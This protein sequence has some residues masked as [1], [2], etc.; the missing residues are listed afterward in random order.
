MGFLDRL[1]RKRIYVLPSIH[2]SM[3]SRY[4]DGFSAGRAQGYAAGVQAAREAVA[5]LPYPRTFGDYK[6]DALAAI[7]ALREEHK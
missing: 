3:A 1:H 7:D 2:A 5:A 4:A 6:R